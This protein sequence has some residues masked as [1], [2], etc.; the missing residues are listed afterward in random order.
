MTTIKITDKDRKHGMKSSQYRRW[1]RQKLFRQ[2]DGF[3]YA[4]RQPMIFA[5]NGTRPKH[6]P[7][8][9][10][11][12]TRRKLPEPGQP[13]F[14]DPRDRLMCVACRSCVEKRSKEREMKIPLEQRQLASG[15]LPLSVPPGGS[16]PDLLNPPEQIG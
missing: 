1:L 12:L 2:Q 9:M 14:T 6:E 3:C 4:C 11:C 10:A 8:N 13:E 7:A 5:I 15:R 16:L